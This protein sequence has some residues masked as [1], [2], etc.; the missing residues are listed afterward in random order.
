MDEPLTIWYCDV[1][2]EP[3]ECSEHG[4]VIWQTTD[5]MKAY[6]FKIIHQGRCDIRASRGR[7][8]IYK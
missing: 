2:G 3:I 4:Y 5:E 6:N 8:F 7:P 1:C